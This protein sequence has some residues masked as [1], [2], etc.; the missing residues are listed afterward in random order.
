MGVRLQYCFL[1]RRQQLIKGELQ[2]DGINIPPTE[3]LGVQRVM[4]EVIFRLYYTAIYLNGI[5]LCL[6]FLTL[7]CSTLTA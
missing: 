3:A 7:W 4:Y 2:A 6:Y 1:A 5:H